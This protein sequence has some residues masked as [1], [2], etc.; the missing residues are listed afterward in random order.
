[1]PKLIGIQLSDNQLNYLPALVFNSTRLSI[2]L[3][4]NP[5]IAI[6]P[7]LFDN[8]EELMNLTGNQSTILF[9][10]FNGIENKINA[11]QRCF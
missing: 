3:Y 11:N 2:Q 8:L 4:Q 9:G 1:L 5:F 10:N 7:Q 6:E